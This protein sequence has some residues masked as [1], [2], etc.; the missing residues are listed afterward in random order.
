MEAPHEEARN[1]PAP[2]RNP[3]P[4]VVTLPTLERRRSRLLLPT[5]L[6]GPGAGRSPLQA[7][8]PLLFLTVSAYN[9]ALIDL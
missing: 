5:S 8:L 3:L 7:P 4:G 9:T 6:E 1:L 2:E